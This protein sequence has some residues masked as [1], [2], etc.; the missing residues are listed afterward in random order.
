MPPHWITDQ[1]GMCE[2]HWS[3]PYTDSDDWCGEH[4]PSASP[5][6]P[7]EYTRAAVAWA[8]ALIGGD[9]SDVAAAK[10]NFLRLYWEKHGG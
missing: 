6:E 3:Q 4:R 10:R 8:E 2:P 1:S 9:P 7:D 5:A